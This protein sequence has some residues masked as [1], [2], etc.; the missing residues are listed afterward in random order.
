MDWMTLVLYSFESKCC[1]CR[2]D[3]FGYRTIKL[4]I[5]LEHSRPGMGG[6]GGIMDTSSSVEGGICMYSTH[7]FPCQSTT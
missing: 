3:P 5:G 7:A 1:T 4:H 2:C 6:G